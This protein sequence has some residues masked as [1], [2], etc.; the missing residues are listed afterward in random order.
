MKKKVHG[1]S[2]RIFLASVLAVALI[3]ATVFT[4]SVLNKQ[5]RLEE[6]RRSETALREKI[7]ILE[8]RKEELLEKKKREL[9]EDEKIQIARVRFGLMFPNEILFIPSRE[10][11]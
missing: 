3:A 11:K 6:L 5:S 7:A 9:T 8:A 1:K 10:K 4:V 2:H